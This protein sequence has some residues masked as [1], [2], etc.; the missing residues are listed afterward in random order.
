MPILQRLSRPGGFALLLVCL[1]GCRGSSRPH[2]A[3]VK[4]RVLFKDE[5]VT[6][7]DIFFIPDASRGNEGSLASSV[8][9][10]DGSFTLTTHPHGDGV[11]PGAYKVTLSLG[12]RPEKELNKYRQVQTTPLEYTVPAEGL[13]DLVI[14]L[15]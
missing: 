11:M 7:A 10:E 14:K 9:Q 12:R 4:G 1:A 8:L 3:P 6:A 13:P 15:E 5:P 2:L